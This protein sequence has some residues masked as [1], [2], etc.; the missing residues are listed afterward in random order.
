MA[1]EFSN[2]KRV[3]PDMTK[4]QWLPAHYVRT[5]TDPE[6]SERTPVLEVPLLMP[7]TVILVHG[8]NS[9][10]EWYQDAED[11][12]CEG[13][14]KRLGRRSLEPGWFNPATDSYSPKTPDGRR[15]R[16]PVIPF[17]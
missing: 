17:Y 3:T 12:I 14:N 7:G 15:A 5:D 8:V 11:Q 9:A 4:A 2:S 10:G 1:N 6:T 13:L 16:S